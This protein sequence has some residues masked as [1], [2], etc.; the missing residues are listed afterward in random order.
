MDI[1]KYKIIATM[2]LSAEDENTLSSLITTIKGFDS[3]NNG[4]TKL[5]IRTDEEVIPIE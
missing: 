1:M 5:L 2:E 4:P 3:N